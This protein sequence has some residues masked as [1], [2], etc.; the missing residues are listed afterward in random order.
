MKNRKT[1]FE[2][3][4]NYKKKKLQPLDEAQIH[5]H[6]YRRGSIRKFTP[7]GFVVRKMDWDEKNKCVL[8]T[9][10]DYHHINKIIRDSIS[11]LQDL[12][13]TE[14]V[15]KNTLSPQQIDEYLDRGFDE[16]SF[17]EFYYSEID[18]TLR[19]KTI[20]EHVYTYNVLKEFRPK[21]LF[22]DINLSFIQLFDRWLKEEKKLRINTIYKHHQ[23][24]NRF[25]RLASVKGLFPSERNP[26]QNFRL[27]KEKG[28]RISLTAKEIQAIENLVVPVV[29]EDLQLVKD[30]FLFSC[31]TGLRFSDVDTLRLEHLVDGMGGLCIQKKMEKVPKPVILP[32][33]YLFDGKPKVILDKYLQTN[34]P[35][36]RIFPSISNQHA[37]RQLKVIAI[38]A[39][40]NMRL[41]FHIS[42][43]TFGS[44][45]AE[46]TQNPYLIMDL[47]GHSDIKT[48]MIY[49]HS[50]QERINK[51]LQGISWAL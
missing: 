39:R 11:S 23:H 10:K 28:S 40:I 47:M 46:K 25:L 37:N 31:Y 48:S 38:A 24:V 34:Q 17:S 49:I 30:M 35:N 1:I 45:L 9:N 22:G 3:V 5:I 32:L 18:P 6:I 14:I 27:K 26:Y 33:E 36:N 44:I 42:R 7:T 19:H 21:I 16:A 4:F 41:T 20:R 8:P 51:H 50:S 43:H 12:E 29:E 15:K 13:Y 2:P